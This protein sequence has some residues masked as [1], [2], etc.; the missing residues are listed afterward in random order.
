VESDRPG[1]NSKPQAI[2]KRKVAKSV[3][4]I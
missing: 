3:D 4:V 2:K 1:K